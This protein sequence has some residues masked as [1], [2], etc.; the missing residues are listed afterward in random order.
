MVN[1]VKKSLS[2]ILSI[3]IPII[4]IA[5][6]FVYKHKEFKAK[7]QAN[8]KVGNLL[9]LCFVGLFLTIIIFYSGIISA[10][11]VFDNSEEVIFT[12]K[13]IEL[14]DEN[15]YTSHKAVIIANDKEL[16][17]SITEEMYEELEIDDMITVVSRNGAFGI[18]YY[19][20]KEK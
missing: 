17:I 15:D 7:K 9:G 2:I 1:L 10:N 12:E 18:K 5:L 6:F 11:A 19:Q 20:I 16:E 4:L 8:Y 14:I 13:V 3:L